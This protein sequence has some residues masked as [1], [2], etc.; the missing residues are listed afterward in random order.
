MI[1]AAM[2]GIDT[3]ANVASV[4]VAVFA[5]AIGIRA[6]RRSQRLSYKIAAL[7]SKP[8]L[9]IE[10]TSEVNSV[11]V[12]LHNYGVGV[13]IITDAIFHKGNRTSDN[14]VELLGDEVNSNVWLTYQGFPQG[15][16]YLAPGKW[17]RL[18]ELT[19]ELL[20]RNGQDQKALQQMRKALNGI[21]VEFRYTDV[22]EYF[23]NLKAS[24]ELSVD[25]SPYE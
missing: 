5:L 15:K 8:I 11:A 7:S 3:I 20:S 2:P 18:A 1:N 13:A 9:V 17:F 21:Y 25:W 6:D 10:T 14:L 19:T 4:I 23:K 16:H 12:K 22:M 24:A